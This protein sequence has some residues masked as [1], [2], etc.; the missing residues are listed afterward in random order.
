MGVAWPGKAPSLH[1]GLRGQFSWFMPCSEGVRVVVGSRARQVGKA[2]WRECSFE[3]CKGPRGK[4]LRLPRPQIHRR[5]EYGWGTPPQKKVAKRGWNQHEG[6][7]AGEASGPGLRATEGCQQGRQGEHT[8]R[9]G[10]GDRAERKRRGLGGSN[11]D[12]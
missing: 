9:S 3:D 8:V 11:P 10:K 5:C 4:E 12:S 1:Q 2:A 6:V 7:R